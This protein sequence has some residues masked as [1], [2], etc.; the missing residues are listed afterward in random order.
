MAGIETSALT[1]GQRL[2]AS[3]TRVGDAV[4]DGLP[5]IVA[6]VLLLLLSWWVSGLIQRAVQKVLAR[7][8]T[9]GHVDLLVEVHVP[10]G[11]SPCQH[12]LHGTLD[13]A[14]H[15][16][17]QQEEQDPGHDARKPVEDGV[18]QASTARATA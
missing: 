8:S 17:G 16:P 2:G 18:A 7:T 11:G 5:G 1:I 14:R 4:I 9:E 3:M 15:P 6:G 10:F 12:L 13:Q